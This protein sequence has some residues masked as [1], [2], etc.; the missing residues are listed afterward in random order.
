MCYLLL[1]VIIPF[2]FL[3]DRILLNCKINYES[4]FYEFILYDILGY[5]EMMKL[6]FKRWLYNNKIEVRNWSTLVEPVLSLVKLFILI[7]V[8]GFSKLIDN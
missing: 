8:Q 1:K 7:N 2:S 4:I 6:I 5:Y 3:F